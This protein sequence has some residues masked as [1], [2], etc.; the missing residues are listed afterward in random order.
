MKEVGV[1]LG[2]GN[3]KVI[4]EGMIEAAAVVVQ[5]QDQEQVQRE[6]N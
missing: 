5:G 2:K 1:G 3:T 4:L 6:T